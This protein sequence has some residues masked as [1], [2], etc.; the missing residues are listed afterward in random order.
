MD[1]IP[2]EKVSL[3]EAKEAMD[4]PATPKPDLEAE[5]ANTRS[6]AMEAHASELNERAWEWLDKLPA[7]IQPGGLVQQFPR[8]ANKLAEI[9][10]RPA[11]CHRYM[12]EMMLDHRGGRKGFPL[13]V[14]LELAKLKA[15]Y[16]EQR[17]IAQK[18]D[19]W[20]QPLA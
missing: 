4:G 11:Q 6:P 9:W 8:I 14:T 12:E 1:F 15:Y 3:K 20:G 7:E 13:D 18:F 19:N 16:E 5:W 10:G 17:G 2:F